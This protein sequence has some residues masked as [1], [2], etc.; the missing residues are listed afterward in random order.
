[1]VIGNFRSTSRLLA[2]A[3]PDNFV[4]NYLLVAHTFMSYLKNKL[5]TEDLEKLRSLPEFATLNIRA[6]AHT[7]SPGLVDI[8]HHW[9]M[10]I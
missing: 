4:A 7:L 2:V 10:V 8:H 5:L 9:E 6:H 3:L 1:M